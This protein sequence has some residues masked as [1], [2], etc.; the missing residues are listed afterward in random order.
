MLF[1]ENIN[2]QISM[3][4]KISD[5]NTF[6]SWYLILD[7]ASFHKDAIIRRLLKR[8]G[9]GFILF[10]A[11]FTRFKSNLKLLGKAKAVS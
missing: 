9:C 3:S 5:K 1:T 4:K 11:I 2:K 6:R 7:N 8:A 10:I